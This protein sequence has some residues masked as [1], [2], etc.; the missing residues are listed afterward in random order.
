MGR[1]H[2]AGQREGDGADD[3]ADQGGRAGAGA[4]AELGGAGDEAAQG[5]ERD[6]EGDALAGEQRELGLRARRVADRRGQAEQPERRA[7]FDRRAAA[8]PA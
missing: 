2:E 8:M 3:E 5:R 7:D 1:R 4:G 6:A